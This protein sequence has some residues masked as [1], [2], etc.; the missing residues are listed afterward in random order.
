MGTSQDQSLELQ[1]CVSKESYA[2]GEPIEATVTLKNRSDAP[3][4]INKRMGIDPCGMPEG[5]WELRFE[6]AYPPGSPDYPVR[7]VNR[8]M[9]DAEDFA[10]LSPGEEMTWS[11]TVSEWYSVVFPGDYEVKAVYSNP[12]DGSAFGL[13]AWV[14]EIVSDVVHLTVTE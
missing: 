9:P 3:L 2:A 7:P 11:Y 10:L 5:Y 6:I 14:G 1:L 12:V 4:T 13:S 8:G